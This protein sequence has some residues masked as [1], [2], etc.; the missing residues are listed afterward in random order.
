MIWFIWLIWIFVSFLF[1]FIGFS[2][3]KFTFKL[4]GGLLL[5]LG[6]AIILYEGVSYPSGYVQNFNSTLVNENLTVVT[7]SGVDV[8]SS[9]DKFSLLGFG[10]GVA[11]IIIGMGICLQASIDGIKERKEKKKKGSLSF[12]GDSD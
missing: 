5:I 11:F 4:L 9:F 6:G 8:Y 7:S 2:K 1:L 10:F 12:G 3:N